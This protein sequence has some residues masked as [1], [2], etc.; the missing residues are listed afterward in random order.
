M[1]SV[2]ESTQ[3]TTNRIC[4][5]NQRRTIFLEKHHREPDTRFF[6]EKRFSSSVSRE[7]TRPPLER[8]AMR[9]HFEKTAPNFRRPK[10]SKMVSLKTRKQKVVFI[11][12]GISSGNTAY[13]R[14]YFKQYFIF[15]EICS[16]IS[17]KTDIHTLARYTGF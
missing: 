13:C 1:A 4:F 3:L 10:Y 7:I 14:V 6:S 2:A 12:E 11:V 15:K 5:T 9:V 16:R 17:I 8:D